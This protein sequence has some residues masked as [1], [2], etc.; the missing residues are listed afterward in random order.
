[1]AEK[2]LEDHER[3]HTGKV[4]AKVRHGQDA[5][6]RI[7]RRPESIADVWKREGLKKFRSEE[8]EEYSR[9]PRSNST[10]YQRLNFGKDLD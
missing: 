9:P 2:H 3:A 1:M 10:V 5:A 7:G 8:A 6:N 4:G